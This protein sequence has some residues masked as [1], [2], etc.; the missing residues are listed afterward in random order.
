VLAV[1]KAELAYEPADVPFASAVLAA[2]KAEFACVKIL[3]SF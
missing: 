3:A 2:A 1:K